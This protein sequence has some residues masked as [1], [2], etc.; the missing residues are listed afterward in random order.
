M[1]NRMTVPLFFGQRQAR[2]TPEKRAEEALS[3][4]FRVDILCYRRVADNQDE[5]KALM[6]SSGLCRVNYCTSGL[7]HRLAW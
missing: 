6:G 5:N 1:P 3:L 4:N 2:G 7:L